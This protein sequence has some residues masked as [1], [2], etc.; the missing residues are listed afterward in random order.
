MNNRTLLRT[1]IA[2]T[3]VA[4]LRCAVPGRAEANALGE[5]R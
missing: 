4:A 1:G 5:R 2:G 3:V